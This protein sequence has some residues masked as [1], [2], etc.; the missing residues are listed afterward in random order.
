MLHYGISLV[1]R[2]EAKTSRLRFVIMEKLILCL[3]LAPG[4]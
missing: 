2:E 3:P 1:S 4:G